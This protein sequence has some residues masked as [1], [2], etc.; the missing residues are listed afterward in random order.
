MINRHFEVYQVNF[1]PVSKNLRELKGRS[2]R[3]LKAEFSSKNG[4]SGIKKTQQGSQIRD[5]QT[6]S[7]VSAHCPIRSNSQDI[8]GKCEQILEA[9]KW[10]DKH[11]AVSLSMSADV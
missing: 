3:S 2:V 9:L 11:D 10:Y 7:S 1:N 6:I 5:F 8:L 4:N